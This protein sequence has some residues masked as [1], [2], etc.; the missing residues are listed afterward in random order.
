MG[1]LS[2]IF[3]AFRG[4]A[5]EV[6]EN[7]VDAQAIRILEQEMRDA[8]K[9]LDEAKENLAKVIAE[10]I[11]VE[12]EI[13]RL[14]TAVEEHEGYAIQALDKGEKKLAEEIAE[15]VADLE[16]ELTTQQSVLENYK[17]N[18]DTLKRHIKEA[19]QN[20]KAMEREINVVK[21]TES[22]QKANA[23]TATKF[24]GS[25]SA[26]RTASES[27]ER[28]KK[29]QQQQADQIKAAMDLQQQESGSGLQEKLREVGI[30]QQ[31]FSSVSVLKRIK[32]KRTSK[33]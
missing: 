1:L 32:A 9:H 3:T 20:I 12:R 14:K 22:V 7:I 2:K 4:A 8:K 6:G 23:A 21:T 17:T 25:D 29:K 30:V 16:N 24:S 15:K 31:K 11:G 33:N 19:D 13:K 5:S 27:L 26:L 28:I 18:I 10:Q